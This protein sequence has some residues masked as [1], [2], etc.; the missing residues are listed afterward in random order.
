M[1]NKECGREEKEDADVGKEKTLKEEKEGTGL[2]RMRRRER[3]REE[4]SYLVCSWILKSCH[5]SASP[6]D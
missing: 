5:R 1:S 6:R 4:G 3:E 2:F